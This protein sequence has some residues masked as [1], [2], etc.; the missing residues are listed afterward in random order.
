[1]R[2]ITGLGL[3]LFWVAL[4]IL[5]LAALGW[6]GVYVAKLPI[7]GILGMA[8]TVPIILCVWWISYY[9]ALDFLDEIGV[10]LEGP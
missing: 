6:A 2:F 8:I 1:M 3:A 4:A 5:T 10:S 7:A 9:M